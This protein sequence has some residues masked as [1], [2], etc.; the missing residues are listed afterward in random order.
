MEFTQG[1]EDSFNKDYN[2]DLHSIVKK[3]LGLPVVFTSNP[4]G[5]KGI[6]ETHT[7]PKVCIWDMSKSL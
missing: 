3:T 2:P 1:C 6:D 5:G 7:S 4:S